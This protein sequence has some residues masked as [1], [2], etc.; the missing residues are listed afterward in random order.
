ML[1]TPGIYN[2]AYFEH[3]FLAQ[4]MGIELVE[5][6]DLFVVDNR[7]YLRTTRGRE[8]VDV[9]YR[10]VDDEFLDP[11]AFR[12]DSVL[13]VAGLLGAVRTGNVALANA[14]GTGVA[15]DKV[16]YH[17]V[18]A[19]IRYYLNEEPILG[20]VPTYLP[21]DPDQRD[22]ILAH[23]GEL[24]IKAANESG[25]YG[26]LIGPQRERRGD[27]ATSA[28]AS[29]PTRATTSP[30]PSCRSPAAPRSSPTR[31][32]TAAASKGGTSTCA[33][34]SSA[35]RRKSTSS[36]AASPASPSVAAR[37]SSIRARAAAAKIRGCCDDAAYSPA[38]PPRAGEGCLYAMLGNLAMHL[39]ARRRMP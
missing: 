15:D 26:M 25:G 17:Y 7:V 2:S 22:Y 21:S 23:A 14:I 10:R 24:V 28:R 5:G 3:A 37:S 33:P 31:A 12:P 18:P 1:L 34:T 13:G 39:Y 30:S 38:P 16:I 19:I 20:N 32:A 6:R 8:P 9:I 11:L 35:A 4:Q 36:P 29:P 27:R